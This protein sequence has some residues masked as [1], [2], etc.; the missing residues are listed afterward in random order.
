MDTEKR[1]H[2]RF[3]PKG[4]LA[5]ITIE[6]PAPEE[7]IVVEGEIVNMSYNGIK[8]RLS[9]PLQSEIDHCEIKIAIIMPQSGIPISIHGIIKHIKQQCEYG[10]QFADGHTEQSIDHLM[11]ECIKLADQ[12]IQI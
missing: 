4:L 10:L 6:P 12:S 5:N 2:P 8:I 11:F 7:E 1:I 9:K 3:L